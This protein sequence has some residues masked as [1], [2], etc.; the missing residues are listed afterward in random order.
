MAAQSNVF[1]VLAKRALLCIC[2]S[3]IVCI[4][5]IE[6]VGFRSLTGFNYVNRIWNPPGLTVGM[7]SERMVM[8]AF[9]QLQERGNLIIGEHTFE[10]PPYFYF[11][12]FDDGL[13]NSSETLLVRAVEIDI[14][15][16]ALFAGVF[17]AVTLVRQL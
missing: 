11:W 13:P 14:R 3:I 12:R 15:I 5:L 9:V 1:R 8:I 4:L 6:L 10:L 2:L 17:P 7:T 16:L